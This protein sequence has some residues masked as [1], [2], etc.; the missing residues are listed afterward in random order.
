MAFKK[1]ARVAFSDVFYHEQS[2]YDAFTRSELVV[3]SATPL[4]FGMVAVRAASSNFKEPYK[5]LTDVADLADNAE[6][7]VLIG[8]KY[9]FQEEWDV[10]ATATD[11]N[12]VGV[13]RGDV[14]IKDEL[15]IA[16]TGFARGSANYN[17]LKETMRKQGMKLEHTM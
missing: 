12:S 13:T 8:D 14:M 10:T 11:I 16:F 7:A 3:Q 17:V 4:K 6:V 9:S 15:I 2:S 1:I 5:V